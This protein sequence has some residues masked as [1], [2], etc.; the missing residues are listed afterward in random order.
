MILFFLSQHEIFEKTLTDMLTIH[1]EKYPIV[2]LTVK[3]VHTKYICS[4]L[5]F[6]NKNHSKIGIMSAI[7]ISNNYNTML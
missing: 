7:W 5:D 4:I 6:S 1:G 2:F 3:Y